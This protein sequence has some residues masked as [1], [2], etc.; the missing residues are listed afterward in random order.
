MCVLT[1]DGA[2]SYVRRKRVM[3]G[4]AVNSRTSSPL[5]RMAV[6]RIVTRRVTLVL[7]SRSGKKGDKL[8][9]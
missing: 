6:S 3:R 2:K 1:D 8:P 5:V 9:F 4:M 7:G